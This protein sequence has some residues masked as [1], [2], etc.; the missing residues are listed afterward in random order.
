MVFGV[1]ENDTPHKSL[2]PQTLEWFLGKKFVE[3]RYEA[4]KDLGRMTRVYKYDTCR[5]TR[6]EGRKKKKNNEGGPPTGAA[7]HRLPQS[8]W[9]VD[10]LF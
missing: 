7:F 4:T 1:Q 10:F 2:C 6:T 5:L 8:R 3:D 9:V